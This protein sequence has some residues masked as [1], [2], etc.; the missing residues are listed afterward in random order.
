MSC[1]VAES[2]WDASII[3]VIFSQAFFGSWVTALCLVLHV[4]VI[5]YLVDVS[6]FFGL[7]YF[8]KQYKEKEALENTS[9]SPVDGM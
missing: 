6:D 5:N 2:V 9:E 1:A 7:A 8:E 4:F 3:D